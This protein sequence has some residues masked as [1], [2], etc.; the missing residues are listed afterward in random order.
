[1]FFSKSFHI[2]YLITTI[3]WCRQGRVSHP[4]FTF[5]RKYRFRHIKWFQAHTELWQARPWKCAP[6][7]KQLCGG[8]AP[9]RVPLKGWTVKRGYLSF[10]GWSLLINELSLWSFGSYQLCWCLLILSPSCL[11]QESSFNLWFPFLIGNPS[12][13]YTPTNCWVLQ[14]LWRGSHTFVHKRLNP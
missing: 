13:S 12:C 4:H 7:I 10:L 3:L 9:G 6:E 11:L 2:K 8:G 5:R 14:C 1:M